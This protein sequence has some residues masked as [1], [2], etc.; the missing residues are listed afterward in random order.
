MRLWSELFFLDYSLYDKI[1]R[2]LFSFVFG[3]FFV[4]K[5]YFKI[6]YLYGN[7]YFSGNDF[8]IW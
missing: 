8:V 5:K 4:W 6:Y 3:I 1:N 2:I 7:V